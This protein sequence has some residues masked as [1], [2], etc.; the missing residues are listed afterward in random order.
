MTGRAR[1]SLYKTRFGKPVA[2]KSERPV[3]VP[4]ALAWGMEGLPSRIQF[5]PDRAGLF[6]CARQQQN[7]AQ[8]QDRHDHSAHSRPNRIP[9]YMRVFAGNVGERHW[10][11]RFI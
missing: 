4:A 11:E 3:G 8:E 10:A 2:K 9:D 6:D 5:L 1:I 7:N